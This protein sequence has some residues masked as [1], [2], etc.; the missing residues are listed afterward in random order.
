MT[1][2]GKFY[3]CINYFFTQLIKKYNLVNNT[4]LNFYL[5][6]FNNYINLVIIM[7]NYY[8]CCN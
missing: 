7:Y 5:Q 3:G 1:V 2:V 6:H 4:Y 8:K